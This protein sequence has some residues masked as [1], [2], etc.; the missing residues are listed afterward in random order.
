MTIT[1]LNVFIL[2]GLL[3]LRE[4]IV[5]VIDDPAI[6]PRHYDSYIS[7]INEVRHDEPTFEEHIDFLWILLYKREYHTNGEMGSSS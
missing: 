5:C 2:I 7:L 4:D 1:L 6:I 3:I